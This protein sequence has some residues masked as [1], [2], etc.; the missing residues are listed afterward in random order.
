M[1]F[2]E[3]IILLFDMVI[4]FV[5]C[6]FLC[7]LVMWIFMVMFGV[8]GGLMY[9]LLMY[10]GMVIWLNCLVRL[11]VNVGV[12]VCGIRFSVMGWMV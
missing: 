12:I 1:F 2:I 3:M 10:V 8:V 4:V 7:F 11:L 9:I 6:V 5:M